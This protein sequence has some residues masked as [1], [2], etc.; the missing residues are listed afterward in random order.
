MDTSLN[1]P[2]PVLAIKGN[3][4]QRNNRNQARGRAFALVVV[5]ASQDSNV[6]TGTFSLNDHFAIVFFDSGADYNFISTNFLPLIDLKPSVISPGYEIKIASGLKVE[7]NKIVRGCRLE[8]EG[9]TFI[10]DL[11]PFGHVSFDVIVGMDWLSKLRAKI[12]C[13]EKIVKIPL[14]NGENLEVHRE[15]PEGNLKQLKSMKVMRVATSP[16]RLEPTEMQELSNQLKELQDKGFI[17]PSSSPRGAPVLFVKKGWVTIFFKYLRSGYHQ[18]RV[19]IE[20][21]PKTAFRMR[22]GHFEFIVMPF[23]LTNALAVFMDLMNRLQ[24]VRFLGHVVNS[25]GKH[26]D[27]N[28][29]EA[30]KNWKPSKTPTEIRSF[31]GLA[32]YYRRFIVNFLK[33]AKPLTLLTQKNKKFEWGNEQENTFQT[34]KDMLCDASI[35]A[36][37]EGPND[38]V[39]Y[40]DASNQGFGCVLMQRNKNFS[41]I[42]TVRSARNEWMKSRRARA[43]SITIHSSFKARILEAWSEASK[44]VN[45]LA[46]MLKGLDK[47]FERKYDGGLYLAE[48]IWVPV[49]GNLRTLILNAA[50]TTKY[51][52]HPGADKMYLRDLYW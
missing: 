28:K 11:I 34:L 14:C 20:D 6:M 26:V 15:C 19:R 49:Y 7:T 51:Y 36:L 48:R 50:H 25:K 38:I 10:I 41:V 21:N 32:G 52:V 18:L 29:M 33:I 27:P 43:M 2:N 30:V 46:E 31:L 13:F 39:V 17:R 42:M 1:R 47:Q 35:L 37:P 23:G 24:E 16:Y 44:G 4:N 8:L 12:V 40:C 22:L 9:H 3:P 45:T 5:E